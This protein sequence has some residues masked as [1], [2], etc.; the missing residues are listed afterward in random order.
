MKTHLRNKSA[1]PVEAPNPQAASQSAGTF[2]KP[3]PQASI[4]RATEVGS[5]G[6]KDGVGVYGIVEPVEDE[7]LPEHSNPL[8][9][10]D[11][12]DLSQRARST[13]KATDS[14]YARAILKKA[15]MDEMV[16]MSKLHLHPVQE[17]HPPLRQDLEPADSRRMRI[18]PLL[19]GVPLLPWNTSIE[20]IE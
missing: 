4:Q 1:Q 14:Y 19:G 9:D 11:Q 8:G 10:R 13:S 20:R 2:A 18:P 16:R 12:G 7:S 17:S 3:Q 6:H 15:E 5:Q